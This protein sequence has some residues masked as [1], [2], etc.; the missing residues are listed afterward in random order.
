MSEFKVLPIDGGYRVVGPDGRDEFFET[1]DLARTN[2]D[3]R[4]LQH[5]NPRQPPRLYWESDDKDPA[6]SSN[7]RLPSL[8]A[9]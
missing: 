9:A 3:E 6:G 8:S 5:L 2:R 4:Q 1:Y 7:R